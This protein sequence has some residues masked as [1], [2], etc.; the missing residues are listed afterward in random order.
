MKL[1]ENTNIFLSTEMKE[2]LRVA[3]FHRRCSMGEIVREA[4]E[5]WGW[6][7]AWGGAFGKLGEFG[8][9]EGEPDPD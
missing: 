2:K 9:V 6:R 3:A 1:C 5:D 8:E 4:L 7:T